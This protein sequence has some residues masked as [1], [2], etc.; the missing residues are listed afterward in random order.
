MFSSLVLFVTA[1]VVI[2][3]FL[4]WAPFHAQRL[5]YVYF[6]ESPIFRVINE[7][8]MYIS[9]I[10]YY[11]SSTIN[12][13]LYNLMSIKYR[14]AFRRTL[15]GN[16]RHLRQP[17]SEAHRQYNHVNTSC[18]EEPQSTSAKS[19]A[20][21]IVKM[22]Q[23]SNGSKANQSK[24]QNGLQMK[25]LGE[26]A[27]KEQEVEMPLSQ[28]VE[29]NG[30]KVN[31]VNSTEEDLK[32]KTMPLFCNVDTSTIEFI[33]DNTSPEEVLLDAEVR[34]FHQVVM[35]NQPKIASIVTRDHRN[36]WL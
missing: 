21:R 11:I 27:A 10:T 20:M 16:R 1:V 7:Y 4:C 8:L 22:S 25:M 5:G 31:H 17:Y 19:K 6:K 32:A 14:E 3:F 26:A 12:P 23:N 34:K 36:H 28:A 13:I 15:C 35:K 24:L 2:A 29:E 9:G 33:D 18:W 30:C